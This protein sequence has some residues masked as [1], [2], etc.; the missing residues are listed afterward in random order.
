MIVVDNIRNSWASGEVTG[1]SP[2]GGLVGLNDVGGSIN[3]RNYQLNAS[4]GTSVDLA[5]GDGI[6]ESFVLGNGD[7]AAGLRALE[8]LSGDVSGSVGN[9]ASYGTHSEWHAGFDI[10]DP[11]D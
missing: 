10:S 7:R 5:T 9:T 6:G 1:D 4:A 11:I 2:V 8:N 3:G